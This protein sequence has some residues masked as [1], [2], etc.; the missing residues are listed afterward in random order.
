MARRVE[1]AIHEIDWAMKIYGKLTTL[2]QKQQKNI[3]E[4]AARMLN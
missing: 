2:S 4:A 3:E 1:A